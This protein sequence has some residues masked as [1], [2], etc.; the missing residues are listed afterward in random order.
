M[1]LKADGDDNFS[2]TR[3]VCVTLL[4]DKYEVDWSIIKPRLGLSLQVKEDSDGNFWDKSC[5]TVETR[6]D[7]LESAIFY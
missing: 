2:T 4:Q 6:R 1:D 7:L 5:W 3:H